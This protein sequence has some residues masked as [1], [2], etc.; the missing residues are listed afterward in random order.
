MKSS[1]QSEKTVLVSTGVNFSSCFMLNKDEDYSASL[2]ASS[3]AFP[4]WAEL[5]GHGRASILYS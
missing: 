3:N 1:P 2:A 5:D 4:K